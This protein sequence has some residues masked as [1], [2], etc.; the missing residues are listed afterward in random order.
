MP[1]KVIQCAICGHKE[2]ACVDQ[3]GRGPEFCPTLAAPELMARVKAEYA[4][5]ETLAFAKAA[6]IQESVCYANRQV[7]PYVLHPVK[8]R[9]QEVV[10][11]AQ[12]MGY[13]RIGVAFC[14]GLRQ[15]ARILHDIL[16]AQGF[17]VVSAVC[18]VGAVPKEELGVDDQDKIRRGRF[19]SMCSPIGQATILNEAGCHFNVL[20]GLCVGHDSLFFR[21]AQAPTTVLVAKDRV[22]GHNPAAALYT[23][24]SYYARLLRPGIDRE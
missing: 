7:R 10:E 24:H 4:N 5:P 9:V 19:E 16:T 3:E 18:K 15:E 12:R 1:E 2:R 8:P 11:F 14:T 13:S 21:H 17:E 20:L 22:T 23:A 6:S